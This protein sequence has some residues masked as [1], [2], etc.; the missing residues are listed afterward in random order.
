MR[1]ED[2]ARRRA[3]LLGAVFLL[4]LLVVGLWIA[5]AISQRQALERC[6]AARRRDCGDLGAQLPPAAPRDYAP[7]R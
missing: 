6:L 7:T 2:R 3:T 4:A 1:Q 5:N